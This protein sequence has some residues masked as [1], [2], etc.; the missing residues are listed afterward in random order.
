MDDEN[1]KIRIRRLIFIIMTKI[2]TPDD[3]K[4][5]R[6]VC[7]LLGSYGLEVGEI[8][9]ELDGRPYYYDDIDW[10]NFSSFDNRHDAD[11]P[12]GLFPIMRKIFKYLEDKELVENLD[13]DDINYEGIKLFID[14]EENKIF[15]KHDYS[16]LEHD[17]GASIIYDDDEEV[18]D[19]FDALAEQGLTKGKQILR[20]SGGGDSGYI[21]SDFESGESVPTIIDEWCYD[22][23]ESN[24]G[25]WEI[26]EGSQGKFIFNFKKKSIELNHTSNYYEDESKKI[27]EE[28]FHL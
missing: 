18:D 17:D 12:D 13:F 28:S 1:Y 7:R 2:L 21:E 5:L 9:Y 20:Y 16:W 11:I 22:K 25:G 15:V 27:F 19:I 24:Y 23:L 10:L 6:S 4:Y 3:K 8:V 26:N 14:C